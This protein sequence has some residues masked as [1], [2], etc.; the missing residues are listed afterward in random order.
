[1]AIECAENGLQ[2][3]EMFRESPERFDMIFMDIHMPD[4]DGSEATRRIR[5]LDAPRAKTAPIIAMTA[6]VFREDI[7]K[8]LAA[9]MNGHIGKP[10]DFDEVLKKM[11]EYLPQKQA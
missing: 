5:G 9:G 7:E 2:A 3:L 4:M 1:V 10:V 8:C 11:R 6:T